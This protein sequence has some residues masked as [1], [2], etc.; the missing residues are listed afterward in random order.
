MVR[1]LAQRAIAS[2]RFLLLGGGA[3]RVSQTTPTARMAP[4]HGAD[5]AALTPLQLA[6]WLVKVIR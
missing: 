6:E 4:R 3:P 2:R 1:S 5:V